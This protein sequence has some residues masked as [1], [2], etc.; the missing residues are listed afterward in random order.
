MDAVSAYMQVKN[1]VETFTGAGKWRGASV[2]AASVLLSLGECGFIPGQSSC[3]VGMLTEEG[4]EII[5]SGSKAKLNLS[6]GECVILGKGQLDSV[7]ITREWKYIQQ[8][9]E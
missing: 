1:V 7:W 9:N 2:V 8:R 5:A 4:A 6:D 3:R